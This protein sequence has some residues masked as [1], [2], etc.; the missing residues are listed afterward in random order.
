MASLALS[1][2]PVPR[3]CPLT[4]HHATI[5]PTPPF[6]SPCCPGTG[7]SPCCRLITRGPG[8]EGFFLN[9]DPLQRW[10]HCTKGQ[11]SRLDEVARWIHEDDDVP[12]LDRNL[13]HAVAAD[14]GL[15]FHQIAS[16]YIGYGSIL[17]N[18][19]LS[20]KLLNQAVVVVYTGD[21]FQPYKGC[22]DISQ[23]GPGES[24]KFFFFVK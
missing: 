4:I 16:C 7:E 15:H 22:S 5:P 8:P 21:G 17:G 6:S 2:I 14:L 3:F 9:I 24:Y 10:Y 12:P 18:H 1:P 13:L 20:T 23:T 19:M 11:D